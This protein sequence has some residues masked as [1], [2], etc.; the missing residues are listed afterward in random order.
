MVWIIFIASTAIIVLAA[1]KLAEYGDA[2]SL[3][4]GLGGLFIG[5]VLLAGATSLPEL[6][7]TINSIQMGLPDLAAGNLFGSNIFNML[8]I[9]MIDLLDWKIRILRS[10]ARRHTL[11]GLL[12]AMMTALAVF[13][14]LADI[15]IYIGWVG[16]D[17]LFLLTAYAVGLWIVR[18]ESNSPA[19]AAGIETI[20]QNTPTLRT[21]VIGFL[22]AAAV[23]VITMPYLVSSSADIAE[24]TGLGTGFIGTAL[25]A[26]I[27]SLPELIAT[28]TAI[29]LKAYDL[30]IGNLLGSNMFNMF[31]I[32]L[33]DIILTD[34]RVIS[35]FSSEFALVGLIALIMTLMA[36]IGNQA[37]LEKK[38]LFIEIDALLLILT[39]IVGMYL[40]YSWKIGI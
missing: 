2:I 22:I 1:V 13:F 31:A 6:L 33:T 30:A 20:P 35:M 27:T 25:V 24:I 28:I 16:L 9:G 32:A 17:S 8:L 23:L 37:Q 39:Y 10:V 7:T 5:F 38:F 11:S 26:L 40:I 14:V 21:G 29:R 36:T 3:R 15:E 18:S 34:S 19:T 12:A 4:T